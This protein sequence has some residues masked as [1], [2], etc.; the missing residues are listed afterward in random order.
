MFIESVVYS[1]FY[2][3][4]TNLASAGVKMVEERKE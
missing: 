2:W 4:R 1:A 3:S